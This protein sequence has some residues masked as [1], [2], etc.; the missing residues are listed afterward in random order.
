MMVLCGKRLKEAS[1]GRSNLKALIIAAA[2]KNSF[3]IADP[4]KV[5]SIGI[6]NV[7]DA[8]E[9]GMWSRAVPPATKDKMVD[10]YNRVK[11]GF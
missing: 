7:G 8:V 1:G 3:D 5:A 9:K 11:A 10:L 6:D 4:E 2:N